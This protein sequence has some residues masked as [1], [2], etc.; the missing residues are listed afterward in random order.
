MTTIAFQPMTNCPSSATARPG[1][2]ARLRTLF[3]QWSAREFDRAQLAKWSDRD[4][5]DAGISRASLAYELNK[6]FWRG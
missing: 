3:A 6:P 5:Q 2:L 1:L 4:L